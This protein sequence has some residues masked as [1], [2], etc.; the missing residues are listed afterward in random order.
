ML[1]RSQDGEIELTVKDNGRGY[2]PP[3]DKNTRKSL[4]FSLME[5]L[6]GELDG[7]LQVLNQ[8][9]L[10]VILRFTPALI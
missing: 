1:F 4:G 3:R 10:T 9:G 6:A 8:G 7:E 5:A 2:I